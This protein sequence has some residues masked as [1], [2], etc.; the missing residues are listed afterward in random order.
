[1]QMSDYLCEDLIVE[2]FTRLPPKSL[3]RF[4]SL[5][6][7]LYSC[8]SSPGFIRIHTFRSP[9]KIL[10]RHQNKEAESFYTLHGEE[11]LSLYLCPKRGYIGI[12]TTISFPSRNNFRTVGSCNGTFCLLFKK[13]VTLWNL[14]IRCKLIVPECPRRSESF[15]DG[16]G[17]GFDPISDDYKV[18]WISYVKDN[19]FVYAVKS[20]TWCEIAS[21]KHQNQISRLRYDA[22]FFSG[23]LHW[24]LIVYQTGL[25]VKSNSCI[26]TFDLSTH[27]FDMIPLPTSNRH[28]IMTGVTNI[29]SSLGLISYSDEF[30]ESWIRVWRDDSWSGVFKLNTDQLFVIGVWQL[31]PQPTNNGDLLLNTYCQGLHVYNHKTGVP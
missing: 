13:C 4:R 26:L 17:L 16:I 19:S 3:I 1:M 27:V 24:V 5:S 8:I 30:N 10:F 21:P 15:L 11:E 23:V 28:W 6:K 22:F 14:S 31:Q 20:G 18:V 12:T 25:P 2:I 29:Q 7:S 9:Q